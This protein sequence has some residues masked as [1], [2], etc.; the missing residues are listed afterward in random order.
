MSSSR[1]LENYFSDGKSEKV[2][3]KFL[4][5]LESYFACLDDPGQLANS[6]EQLL[7]LYKN[8]SKSRE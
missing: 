5:Y 3:K 1:Q 8:K 4:L 2:S 7:L 6:I